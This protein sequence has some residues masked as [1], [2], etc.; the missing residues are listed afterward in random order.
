M[1]PLGK[2]GELWLCLP[3]FVLGI[4]WILPS[5]EFSWWCRFEERGFAKTLA[6]G[7][8]VVTYLIAGIIFL[9]SCL[10]I[11]PGMI[12]VMVFVAAA[13]PLVFLAIWQDSKLQHE[14]VPSFAGIFF[15]FV[16]CA[17]ASLVGLIP[18]ALLTDFMPDKK[19]SSLLKMYPGEVDS[20]VM[21][22]YF[23]GC[24]CCFVGMSLSRPSQIQKRQVNAVIRNRSDL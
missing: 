3:P 4:L 10:F 20:F 16:F 2:F 22:F 24:I 18:V 5:F 15:Q 23:I 1:P 13:P 9:A 6:F 21:L 8:R 17:V 7:F 14:K 12:I 19:Q 11:F